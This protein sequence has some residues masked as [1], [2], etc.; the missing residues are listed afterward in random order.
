MIN[1]V[2]HVNQLSD[3][4]KNIQTEIRSELN[5]EFGNQIQQNILKRLPEKTGRVKSSAKPIKINGQILSQAILRFTSKGEAV[6]LLENKEMLSE[7][8]YPRFVSFDEEP[9]LED[10]VLYSGLPGDLMEKFMK[11]GGVFVGGANTNFG[12]FANRWFSNA[13]DDFA[14][15]IDDTTSRI[16]NKVFSKYL[17]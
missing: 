17:K 16:I 4:F 10:W 6:I 11:S 1:M 7:F 3:L 2:V 12:R 15:T 8:N 14:L 9:E 5:E 13:T